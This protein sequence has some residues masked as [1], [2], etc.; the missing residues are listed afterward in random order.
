MKSLQILYNESNHDD[1]FSLLKRLFKNDVNTTTV[2]Q[3]V[4]DE[5]VKISWETKQDPHA[6]AQE[7]TSTMP[8]LVIDTSSNNGIDTFSRFFNGTQLW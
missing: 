8:N 2:Y 3:I 1:L 7:L 5:L 6:L 4:P